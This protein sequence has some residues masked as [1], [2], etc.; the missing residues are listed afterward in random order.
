MGQIISAF[1][2]MM[3]MFAA[4]AVIVREKARYRV[5]KTYGYPLDDTN[6]WIW[7]TLLA[8]VGLFF[9]SDAAGIAGF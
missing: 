5:Y 2:G 4:F 9:L 6:M 8:M 7:P 3:L 1:I